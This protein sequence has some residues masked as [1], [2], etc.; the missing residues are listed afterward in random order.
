MNARDVMTPNPMTIRSQATVAEAWDLMGEMEIRHVP[1]VD[2]GTLVGMLSDR[3][4]GRLE[5]TR[6]LVAEGADA[7]RQELATPVAK[8]MSLDVIAA[9]PETELGDIV[10]V[11]VEH[12]VGALPV[13]HPDTRELVG[14]IS[15]VD[16]LR[17][18]QDR[19]GEE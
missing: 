18:L 12:K 7:L 19:L 17:A 5:V 1:V 9:E 2:D 3:D 15:Y 14:I 16:V 10:D 6:M 4:L 8:L 11:L 13:V